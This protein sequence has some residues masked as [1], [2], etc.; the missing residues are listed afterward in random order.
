MP[1]L[2]FVSASPDLSR[3]RRDVETAAEARRHEV[4]AVAS[5]SPSAAEGLAA[6]DLVVYEISNDE[7][8]VPIYRMA[9]AAA[10]GMVVLPDGGIDRVLDALVQIDR[11]EADLAVR[12]GAMAVAARQPA[13]EP[14][15]A[16]LCLH[17]ARRATALIAGNDAVR[18]SLQTLGCRTPILVGGSAIAD[19]IDTIIRSM[20]G[21][22]E[23]A[24]ARWASAL[25]EI[26]VQP[27]DVE[28]GLG[29]RYADALET[30]VSSAGPGP[31]SS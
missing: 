12:E 28:R 26:G 29:A 23:K 5:G 24:L 11:A 7:A 18:T 4:V 19:A 31:S 21:P 20:G 22:I 25:A 2:A 1:R 8:S 16:A 10:P 13:G 3:L 6:F 30:L 14:G 27:D 9:S 17:L 15:Y